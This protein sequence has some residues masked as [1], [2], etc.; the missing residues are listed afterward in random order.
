MPWQWAFVYKALKKRLLEEFASLCAG[1]QP[2]WLGKALAGRGERLS[3]WDWD[4]CTLSICLL[5]EWAG[6]QHGFPHRHDRDVRS[7]LE[8]LWV[9]D[10][11]TV[12]WGWSGVLIEKLASWTSANRQSLDMLFS[13]DWWFGLDCVSVLPLLRLVF[14]PF[15]TGGI[16][17]GRLSSLL[18]KAG[19]CE[20]SR[21]EQK[22]CS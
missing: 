17:A 19:C 16:A 22:Q 1:L 5:G 21:R 10:V 2:D 20:R 12:I 13:G 9:F 7:G 14:S 15:Q 4:C 3:W 18:G 11:E 6:H 8:P